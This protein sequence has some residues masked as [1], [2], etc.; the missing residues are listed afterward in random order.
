MLIMNGNGT[1]YPERYRS[2]GINIEKLRQ[3]HNN[4]AQLRYRTQRLSSRC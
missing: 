1:R 3:F 2:C 4:A